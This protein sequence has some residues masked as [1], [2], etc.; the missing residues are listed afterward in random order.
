MSHLRL[1]CT[2]FDFDWGSAPDPAGELT[3]LP[4][5]PI[6]IKG[7]LLLKGGDGMGKEREGRG[8]GWRRGK[9]GER[10]GRV[11]TGHLPHG[12]LQTLAAMPKLLQSSIVAYSVESLVLIDSR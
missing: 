6:W 4:R 3:S 8:K 7:V 11:G 9:G 10:R 5:P 12:Q 1:K 2:K